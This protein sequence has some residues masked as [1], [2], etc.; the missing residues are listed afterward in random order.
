MTHTLKRTFPDGSRR[1]CY[2]LFFIALLAS[3]IGGAVVSGYLD[4]AFPEKMQLWL[5][6]SVG[7]SFGPIAVDAMRRVLKI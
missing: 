6:A 4:A 3:G 1:F 7:G 2:G 5:A